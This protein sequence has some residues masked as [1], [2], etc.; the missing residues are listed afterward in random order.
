[1]SRRTRFVHR[2]QDTLTRVCARPL[3]PVAAGFCLGAALYA[4]PP[5][6]AALVAALAAAARLLRSSRAIVATACLVC[7]VAAAAGWLLTASRYTR[8]VSEAERLP[9]AGYVAL[10][11]RI[12]GGAEPTG[13]DVQFTVQAEQLADGQGRWKSFH[14]PVLVRFPSAPAVLYGMRVELRGRVERSLRRDQADDDRS[15]LRLRSRGMAALVVCR[16]PP[17]VQSDDAGPTAWLARVGIAWR[18]HFEERVADRLAPVDAALVAGVVFG[19]GAGLPGPIVDAFRT[20]GTSHLLAA[21]G[22]NVGILV[23]AMAWLCGVLTLRDRRQ[24]APVVAVVAAYTVAAGCQ[25]SVVRAAVTA[26]VYLSARVL[27]REPDL[28]C[29]IAAAAL[30]IL[31]AEP[32]AM[33][34]PGFQLSFAIVTALVISAPWLA[35]RRDGEQP[36]PLAQAQDQAIAAA[37]VCLVANLAAAPLAAMHFNGIS[38]TGAVANLLLIPIASAMLVGGMALWVVSLAAP[39]LAAWVAWATLGP[40]SAC[41]IGIADWASRL[42]M[43]SAVLASPPWWQVALYYAGLAAVL[44]KLRRGCT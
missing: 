11:G 35:L 37:K 17:T 15:T 32:L 39:G 4:T 23:T 27:D 2:R 8:L 44:L 41:A 13:D 5:A 7:A 12:A 25:P 31:I 3:V 29:A 26:I 10:R 9:Q 43:G 19:G 18:K 16:R 14:A 24:W 22:M 1:M 40:M 20:T 28:A 38:L 21:S 42:P 33:H 36:N 34:A 6:A 30:G